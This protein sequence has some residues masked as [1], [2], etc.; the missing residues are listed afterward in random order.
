MACLGLESLATPRDL[1]RPRTGL[2]IPGCPQAD[3]VYEW[4]HP[5]RTSAAISILRGRA[6]YFG[7]C[8]YSAAK[9][10]E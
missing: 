10:A 6:L 8:S 9:T 3:W 1:R 4:A 7:V 2:A 5:D